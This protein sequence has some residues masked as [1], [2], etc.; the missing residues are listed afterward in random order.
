M[1]RD[2]GTFE[3]QVLSVLARHPRNAYG[4]TI[5]EWIAE[6]TGRDV[7]IGALYTTLERLEAKG[8]ISSEWGEPTAVRGGRRKRYYSIEAPGQRAHDEMRRLLAGFDQ[9]RPARAT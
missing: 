2:I 4:V 9:R 6:A 8:L 1:I 3:F 7:S 5:R